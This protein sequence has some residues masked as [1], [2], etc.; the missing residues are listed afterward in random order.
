[1]GKAMHHSSDDTVRL[2][3][4]SWPRSPALILAALV[5]CGF[6][7]GCAAI[8]NPVATG[9]SVRHLPEELL[10][11]SK[12]SEQTIPL[13][14]L[15][16]E[17]P[18]TYRLAAGD[19]L[20][21]YVEGFLG[22]R[23][24]PIVPP[25]HVGPLAQARDQRH[26]PPSAGYPIPV[27]DYGTIYLPSAGPLSVQ[28]MSIPEAREA[29][30]NFY[31]KRN[32]LKDT[33][34]R[35]MVSLLHPRHY[36]IVVMRQEAASFTG[37]FEGPFVSSKRGT[38][39]VVDLPAYEN[40]VLHALAQTG[41]LP[42]LDAYNAVII[43]RHC[44]HGEQERAALMR[45][46]ESRQPPA[47]EGEGNGKSHVPREGMAACAN[48]P[49]VRIPLRQLPGVPSCFGPEDVVLQTGDVV[50][51]EARDE[52]LFYTGGLLPPGVFVLPRDQDVDVI[53]AISRVR[54]PLFNGAFGGSNLAG[55]LIAPGIGSPS[56]SLLVV[57]R[58][59]P[60]GGHVPI[61]V[62]LRDALRHPEERL[63]VRAGDV[64][65]LQE[66]P[67][68]AVARY[69]TQTFFNFNL[70][71]QAFHDKYLTGIIDVAAPDRPSPRLENITINPK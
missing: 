15:S 53:E 41:G 36:Q 60:G 65:M 46:L 23:E 2:T 58:R 12:D 9:V 64:L 57:L 17:R 29:I 1:M 11:P 56:P 30:R 63:L 13:T 7:G 69:L 52:D 24:P 28:G 20:G 26:W 66:K 44:F 19:V 54:G 18:P 47:E 70:V 22:E 67:S 33:N 5:V 10:A 50:F 35:I 14:M 49:V 34:Y 62:D 40:D 37:P 61:V 16:Q 4:A 27:E 59:T 3:R 31:V 38:G 6:S 32:L 51:L 48:G 39:F 43:Q 42:G 68:E 25:V 55:N 21:V 71:W 45:Q 8:T